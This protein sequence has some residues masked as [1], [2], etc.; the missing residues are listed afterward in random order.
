VF[1]FENWN[2]NRK[3]EETKCCFFYF[4]IKLGFGNDIGE[5]GIGFADN[6]E[7]K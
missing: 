1:L 7:M 3:E 4:C 6:T 5:F 2:G